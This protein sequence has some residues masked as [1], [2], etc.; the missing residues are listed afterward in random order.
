MT[1][2]RSGVDV[3]KLSHGSSRQQTVV[4][5]F[6]T[7]SSETGLDRDY[8]TMSAT[9]GFAHQE[10]RTASPVAIAL[11]LLPNLALDELIYELVPNTVGQLE[12]IEQ[13]EEGL[14]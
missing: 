10:P 6:A 13:Y 12:K 14:K 11:G 2:H 9:S 3:P 4:A 8:P 1:R 7:P 5:S